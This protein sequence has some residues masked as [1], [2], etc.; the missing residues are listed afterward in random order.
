MKEALF[1]VKAALSDYVNQVEQGSI[2]EI[3]RH[4]K[5]AVVLIGMEEYTMY[6]TNFENE[7]MSRYLK[8]KDELSEELI[9]NEFQEVV[10][11]IRSKR[12]SPDERYSVW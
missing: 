7:F 2:V 4:G 3:T 9:Q 10:D 11:A 8:W 6:Q 1:K 12:V 5:T